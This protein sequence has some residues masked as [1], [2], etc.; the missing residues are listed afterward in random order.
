MID[1]QSIENLKTRLDIVDVVGSYLELK[2][3]GANWKCVCPFHDDSNPSLVVSPSKQIYHCFSCGAGGDSIKFVMEY[4]KLSYPETIEKLAS[5]YN[6]SLSYTSNDG[7][8]HEDRKLLENINIFFKKTLDNRPTATE[9]IKN[10]GIGEASVEKFELGY[11]PSS[12]ENLNF[13][14]SHGYTI[15]EAIETGIVGVGEN[16]RNYARF[17]ER[18]TFPIRSASGKIVGFGGRT[19][20]GHQA[21]YVNS[22]QTK[23]FNKSYLL[24]GY[25]FAKD[26]IYKEKAIIVTEGYLDVIMLHQAGFTNAVATLGTALTKEHIPLISRGNPKVIL[27]YDGDSAGVAAALKASL[28]LSSVGINGGVVLFGEN[29]DPADMVQNG[30]SD[31][32][33]RLFHNPQPFIE[34]AIERIVKKYNLQNPLEKQQALEEGSAYLKTLPSS[35]ANSYA[36]VLSG[37]LNINQNLVKVQTHQSN[38]LKQQKSTFEDT[39]ELT[40]IKTLLTTPNL[41]DTLLDTIDVNMFKTHNAELSALLANDKDHPSLRRILL[42]ED[43]K[44][45]DEDELIASMLN[46]L[47]AFYTEELKKVKRSNMDYKNKSFTIRKMQDKIMKLR[48]GKLVNYE[49]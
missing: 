6:F 35:V 44:V 15:S 19:I 22:P 30:Q 45:Y 17:I 49:R 14:S 32:L 7:K 23:L 37:T 31:K 4:E 47:Y 2:K 21:K 1:T 42:R 5:M 8:T 11:A 26:N 20:S 9:Y 12:Q 24:Y 43:I 13:L 40:I 25:N 46:F 33:N 27:A 48:Q 36:G 18:I 34:F 3:N 28:M 38:R 29:M 39:L 10:R 41:I 16:G